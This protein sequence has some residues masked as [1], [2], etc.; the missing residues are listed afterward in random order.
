MLDSPEQLGAMPYSLSSGMWH[1]PPQEAGQRFK[2][3]PLTVYG[4]YMSLVLPL[5]S[6]KWMT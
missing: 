1:L 4:F 2:P 6:H 5:C 3:C